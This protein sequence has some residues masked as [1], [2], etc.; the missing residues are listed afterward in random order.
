MY[1]RN[2]LR[3]K[4]MDLRIVFIASFPGLPRLQFLIVRLI[5]LPAQILHTASIQEPEPGKAW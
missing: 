3:M 4:Y 5:G 2:R 1:V